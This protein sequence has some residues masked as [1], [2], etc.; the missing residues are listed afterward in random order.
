MKSKAFSK[1]RLQE[2]QR[3]NENKSN[4]SVKTSLSD[5]TN[6][7][8]TRILVIQ[9]FYTFLGALFGKTKMVHD[10]TEDL[11]IMK[12]KAQKW[13]ENNVSWKKNFAVLKIISTLF[14]IRIL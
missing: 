2:M 1:E 5:K 14:L 3:S 10:T 4:K 11:D 9:S 8:K 12:E 6:A 13:K 7:F